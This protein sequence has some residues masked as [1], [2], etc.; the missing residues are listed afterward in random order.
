M[1]N[2]RE[3]L[4]AL[5]ED[6]EFLVGK[7]HGGIW[8]NK[9][10]DKNIQYPILLAHEGK[11]RGGQLLRGTSMKLYDLD[12]QADVYAKDLD[13]AQEVAEYLADF[14]PRAHQEVVVDGEPFN[15]Q[16]IFDFEITEKAVYEP[17][18]KVWR[19]ITEFTVRYRRA[20]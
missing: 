1:P 3:A 11:E 13:D 7:L 6:D 5:L 8:M 10:D 19:C 18:L 16:S 4:Q 20:S 12:F 15:I 9:L 2:A 14:L 17:E